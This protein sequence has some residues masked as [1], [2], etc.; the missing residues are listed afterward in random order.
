MYYDTVIDERVKG[1]QYAQQP[2]RLQH[3]NENAVSFLGNHSL[4]TLCRT[5]SGWKCNCNKYQLVAGCNYEPPFCA[6]VIAVER[7][8]S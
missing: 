8:T 7:L 3:I 1:F 5:E 6:H 4:H 2:D